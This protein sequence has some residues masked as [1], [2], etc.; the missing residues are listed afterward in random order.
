MV[1][2]CLK[3]TT[4]CRSTAVQTHGWCHSVVIYNVHPFSARECLLLFG[5][6]CSF[7]WWKAVY[8]SDVFWQVQT[9]GWCHSVGNQMVKVMKPNRNR[10]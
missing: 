7:V 4:P 6:L 2:N 9:H 1:Q 10:Q 5:L 8:G 3:P